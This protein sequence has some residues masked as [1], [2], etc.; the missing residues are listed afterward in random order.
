MGEQQGAPGSEKGAADKGSSGGDNSALAR[1]L[2]EMTALAGLI[3]VVVGSWV[4]VESLRQKAATDQETARTQLQTA[5]EQTKQ[6]RMDL[7]QE[8]QLHDADLNNKKDEALAQETR[9]RNSRLAEVVSHVFA[10]NGSSEGDLAILSQFLN[11]DEES[12]RIVANAV[13]ARLENPRTKEEID[14]GFRLYEHIGPA[15]WSYVAEVNRSARRRY[16][17]CLLERYS[18]LLKKDAPGK[19]EPGSA[20]GVDINVT[21]VEHHVASEDSL[22]F[23][24]DFATI[25]RML[26]KGE[27]SE[28]KHTA[29]ESAALAAQRILAAA[30]ISRS[31]QVLRGYIGARSGG[32]PR[33]MDLSGTYLESGTVLDPYKGVVTAITNAFTTG[34]YLSHLR[35][36]ELKGF[37]FDDIEFSRTAG[38]PDI[39]DSVD[40][41]L[42][43]L[44]NPQT[45]S[46]SHPLRCSFYRFAP[47]VY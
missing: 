17:E 39:V 31:N 38:R 8:K 9:E 19:T 40:Y 30:E 26:S 21:D 4:S 1:W 20:T 46:K 5:Q 11:A 14:L 2:R 24:Y 13:L 23:E 28:I 35:Q 22:D 42:N 16:D 27:S 32:L 6:H 44:A 7:E 25:N 45:C 18:H 3:A 10:A 43:H 15:A 12:R 29:Q 36:S 47:E 41:E 34:A 33:H 37:L